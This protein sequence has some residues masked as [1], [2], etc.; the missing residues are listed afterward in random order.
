MKFLE[1]LNLDTWWKFVL[2]LGVA[3]VLSSLYFKIDFIKSKHFFGL[4]V[5][6]ILVGI[7]FWIAEKHFSK[8]KPPNVYMGGA[9]LISW[10]KIQ[11]NPFTK[12]LFL[13][14]ISFI[15]IFGF[16]IIKALI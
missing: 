10:K 2:Y 7:S 13:I 6:M 9:A 12:I 5:G 14:G 1:N 15:V 8:I 16:L 11:H 4:G 3:S